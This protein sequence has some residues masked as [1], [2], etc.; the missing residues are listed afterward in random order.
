M[1]PSRCVRE[2]AS[3]TSARPLSTLVTDATSGSGTTAPR[4]FARPDHTDT[5]SIRRCDVSMVMGSLMRVRWEVVV[6][7]SVAEVA[8]VVVATSGT[9]AVSRG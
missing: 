2:R 6:A 9:T 7:T 3:A 1:R 8:Q 5:A 4:F